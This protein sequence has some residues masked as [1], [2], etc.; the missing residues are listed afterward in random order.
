MCLYRLGQS[1]CCTWPIIKHYLVTSCLVDCHHD[2]YLSIYF[3][4]TYVTFNCYVNILTRALFHTVCLCLECDF[5]LKTD[6][7]SNRRFW[8][9]LCGMRP[10][11]NCYPELCLQ[12]FVISA[13]RQLCI[14]FRF[15]N[16]SCTYFTF[17]GDKQWSGG[18]FQ[19][20]LL[21][22]RV[23]LWTVHFGCF[24]LQSLVIFMNN[25]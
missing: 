7:V 5:K 15:S 14:S 19:L 8:I 18:S 21:L 1:V 25:I 9:T 4:Y 11:S 2:C 16:S 10:R 22:F 20:E 3:T 24:C 6:Y 12:L 23:S 13:A 17:P